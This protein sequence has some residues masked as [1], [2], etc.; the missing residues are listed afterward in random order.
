VPSPG[1]FFNRLLSVTPVGYLR[2]NAATFIKYS[3]TPP[4]AYTELNLQQD[5]I[6]TLLFLSS[7]ITTIAA[8]K[9]CLTLVGY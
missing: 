5:L 6:D 2:R 3:K 9:R 4:P 8:Q 7:R 1:A